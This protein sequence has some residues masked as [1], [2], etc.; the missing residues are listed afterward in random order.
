MVVDNIDRVKDGL[1]AFDD[2]VIVGELASCLYY[3]YSSSKTSY[4][5][6]HE[7]QLKEA[8]MKPCSH[9]LCC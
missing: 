6:F 8:E 2:Q 3:N 4:F 9:V 1:L 7:R 5:L